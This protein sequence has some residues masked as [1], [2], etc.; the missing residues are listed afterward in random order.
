VTGTF[1]SRQTG[2]ENGP[3]ND[4]FDVTLP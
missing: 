1:T 2:G 4:T 3:M